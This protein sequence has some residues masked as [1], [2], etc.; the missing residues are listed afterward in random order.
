MPQ[1]CR[2]AGVPGLAGIPG[3]PVAAG[4]QATRQAAS[5]AQQRAPAPDEPLRCCRMAA[6]GDAVACRLSRLG[7]LRVCYLV[8]NCYLT[9]W[10]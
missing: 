2:I 3:I 9:L 6:A 7:L 4:A 1:G 8:A 10:L 5:T